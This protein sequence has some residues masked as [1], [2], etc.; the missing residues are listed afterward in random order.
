MQRSTD[1][2]NFSNLGTTGANV[3]TF[4]DTTAAA[5]TTYHYRVIASN[6]AGSSAPSSSASTTT[7]PAAP[8]LTASAASSSQINLSWTNV[9]G[10]TGYVVE[11][12]ADGTSGWSQIGTTAA[13]VTTF[14]NTGL[15]MTTTYFYRV[16]AVNGSGQ[17][18]NSNTASATTP[19]APPAAPTNLVATALSQTQIQL[20]WC[21]VAGE[22]QYIIERSSNGTS[23]WAQVGTTTTNT[24]TFTNTGLKKNTRYYY[25]VRA[26]NSA[27]SSPNSSVV[28]ATTLR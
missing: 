18:V 8:S 25:R 15:Q 20:T 26:V 17:S 21:D 24:T 28:N 23:G 22:T 2:T 7:I 19:L 11:R 4:S 9:A 12:S 14:Q 5:G 16:R 10:E 1:G 6:G 13:N 3:V 27:G